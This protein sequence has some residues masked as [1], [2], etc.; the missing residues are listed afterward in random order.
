MRVLDA[1][2]L[3]DLAAAL[4]AKGYRVVAPVLD[5]DLVRLKDWSPGAAV[6]TDVIPVN[7]IK[8]VLLPRSEVIA[9]YALDA[10]GFTPQD[11]QPDATKTVVLGVRPC[12]AATPAALDT[13]FNWDYADAFY[14]A[15]RA[16]TTIVALTCTAADEQCFCTS[17]GG[18]PDAVAGADAVLRSADHGAKFV[19]EPF[20]EKG[21]AVAEAAGALLSEAVVTVDP[22]AQVP[23]RFDA[24]AVTDWLADNFDSPLWRELSLACLGCGACAYACPACHCFDIQDEATRTQAVRRRN[25]DACGLGLFTLHASGHNP[26]PEQS[27]RWRQR[28][29]HKFSYFPQRFSMLACTGCGR[30][31]RLCP[32]G[33][34]IAETCRRIDESTRVVK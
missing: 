12:D 32:A 5:G 6:R 16:A 28:V 29:M 34:A 3:N 11:V 17:V 19:L 31:A 14:N 30:C 7:S 27:A 26:R 33:M 9:Q 22:P 1:S 8:D 23:Q 25:W 4:T 20:T 18:K 10:D 21:Q 13:V 15:R 2:K 24:K